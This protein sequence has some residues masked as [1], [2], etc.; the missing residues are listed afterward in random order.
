[1]ENESSM[2]SIKN[3]LLAL[4]LA[5]PV[6]SSCGGT[7]TASE[8]SDTVI[9]SDSE[10]SVSTDSS[11]ESTDASTS[12]GGVT[13]ATGWSEADAELM[14]SIIGHEI[15]FYD[16]ASQGLTYSFSTATG[17][18]G[19][20][21][22][23]LEARSCST[24][25]RDEF[26]AAQ[27]DF[28]Y[29]D[30]TDSYAS[31]YGDD[32]V[33]GTT[34]LYAMYSDL[35]AVQAQI[36][37]YNVFGG[38]ISGESSTRGILYAYFFP[39][40]IPSSTWP[41]EEMEAAIQDANSMNL[42]SASLVTP[43]DELAANRNYAFVQ[44]TDSYWN[45]YVLLYVTGDFTGYID[46]LVSA[47][48]KIVP[49]LAEGTTYLY[50]PGTSLGVYVY[51]YDEENDITYLQF[52]KN[53]YL[54]DWPTQDI[55]SLL[56][57][58][59]DDADHTQFPAFSESGVYEFYSYSNGQ[60]AIYVYNVTEEEYEAYKQTLLSAGF[61]DGEWFYGSGTYVDPLREYI[62]TL[63]YG[64]YEGMGYLVISTQTV[65]TNYHTSWDSEI[66]STI[67]GYFASYGATGFEA[68]LPQP[69]FSFYYVAASV[70]E[71]YGTLTLNIMDYDESGSL[72][73]HAS[74]YLSQL[75]ESGW[76]YVEGSESDSTYMGA[77][78][79]SDTATDSM[80][81]YIEEWSRWGTTVVVQPYSVTGNSSSS[82]SETPT[83]YPVL[84]I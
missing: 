35:W 69:S 47:G 83:S 73:A 51:D 41:G 65:P 61:T 14:V 27:I 40:M 42:G 54:I 8:E 2:K 80:V 63:E 29:E 30:Q 48:W 74:D 38:I 12:T 19:S 18:D 59:T 49:D 15:P 11:S 66:Q 58:Y 76:Y 9:S 7:D 3:I 31:L 72:V 6:L 70:D 22:L 25:V 45:Y 17:S 75:L 10:I 57:T 20:D 77:T 44:A 39:V 81:F 23:V 53:Y 62:V 26:I 28:G 33:E 52:G 37:L 79:Y 56:D 82:Y 4:A 55:D 46:E 60:F 71:T 64:V 5:V 84:A 68:T 67:E 43:S 13:A 34:M 24:T 50:Q 16:F 21:V 1:M 32:W 36:F 78:V